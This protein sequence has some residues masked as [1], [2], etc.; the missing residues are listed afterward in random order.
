MSTAFEPAFEPVTIERLAGKPLPRLIPATNVDERNANLTT[1]LDYV[2]EHPDTHDQ[3]T[4]ACGTGACFAGWTAAMAGATLLVPK[5]GGGGADCRTADGRVRS[6]S[7]YAEEVLGLE[8]NPGLFGAD[9]TIDDLEEIVESIINP[10]PVRLV[11]FTVTRHMTDDE[12]DDFE[13]R[14]D[15][16]LEGDACDH[17]SNDRG[18]L[19]TS[20]VVNTG[21][22]V[23]TA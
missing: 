9:N 11:T 13:A 3:S 1:V 19:G 10:K 15:R 8:D 12:R 4:W 2:R 7:D 14:L 21:A 23:G 6:I 5:S 22:V 18:N 17:D 20:C 16:W